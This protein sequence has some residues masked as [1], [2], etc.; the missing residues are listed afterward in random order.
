MNGRRHHDVIIVGAGAV[1]A[2]LALALARQ[3]CRVLLLDNRPGP[4]QFPG[5]DYAGFV[6]SLN[7]ASSAILARL[8]VWERIAGH[9]V[10]PY[11][12]MELW[13]ATGSGRTRFDSTDIGEP[14]L[15]HFVEPALVEAALHEA[16]AAE[17]QVDLRWDAGSAALEIE[18]DAACLTL[19]D[20]TR[21]DAALVVGA[22]GG[23]SHLRELAGIGVREYDYGQQALVC[24][25]TTELS[26][27]AVA[28]QRF[29]PGGPVAMLPL[30]DGR[31]HLAWFRPPAEAGELLALDDNAF[32]HAL[33]EAT[34][35][36]LGAVTA[37]TPRRG[38]PVVR[39]HA[40]QYVEQRIAL[41][42][43]AAHVI[44]PL[45]GQGL[46]LGLLD[47]AALAHAVGTRGDVG[48]RPRLR[49]YARWRRAHN[50][51]VMS[52]MDFFHFGFAHGGPL[53]AALRNAGLLAA[54]RSGFAKRLVTRH[55]AGLAGDLPP[56]ARP[57]PLHAGAVGTGSGDPL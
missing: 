6:V 56:L 49:R 20:D 34:D 19:V 10:S 51:A 26:H 21:L 29:L 46:N 13:D 36:A 48:A 28:R 55:G 57:L 23:R 33:S 54:D 47:A 30:A 16:L 40:L 27:G 9:R 32:C 15:G 5:D 45:A 11:G 12:A 53:R 7:R 52:A 22:D 39:R 3:R 14:M 35:Y 44:H 41:V 25:F 37:A 43:D 38:F 4:A 24:H 31:C 42:G 50:T 8:G 1:G 18:S 2:T 17:P